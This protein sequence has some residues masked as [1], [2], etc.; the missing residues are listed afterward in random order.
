[1]KASCQK[2]NEL[3]AWDLS[4]LYVGIDDPQIEK[5]LAVYQKSALDFA[6]K[7]KDKIASLD[8]KSFFEMAKNCEERSVLG[9]KLGV[10]AYLTMVTQ[11][12]NKEAMT[13]YQNISE[14]LNDY[15]KPTIFLSLEINKLPQNKIDEWLTDKQASY[16]TPWLKRIRMFKDYELSEAVEEILHEKSVTS[17]EGWERLYEET[18]ARLTFHINDT[19]YNDAEISKLTL[20]KDAEIR[21]QAG[22]EIARVYKENAPLFTLNYNMVVKDKA[23]E[24]MKRGFSSPVASQNLA[25]RVDDAAVTALAQ[26]VRNHYADIAHRFYKLKAKWLGVSKLEYWD[27]NAPLPF[28]SERTYSWDEAVKIVLQAYKEFSPKL[29]RLATDFFN[30]QHSWIDVPPRDGKR[31]GAFAMP[32]PDKFH[33]YLFLN[34]VGKQNDVLTLA[35]EL[36]HG[37]HMR[38]SSKQGDLNDST[39][40]TLAEVASVFAEMLTFQSLLRQAQ[41]DKERLCLIAGKV[42]DMINTA[43][44]QI[45]FHFFETR[46]HD[47]RRNGEV[48]QDRLA[49]IWKEEMIASLGDYVNIDEVTENNWAMVGHFFWKP[50]YVY[51]YSF[52]DCLVNSLYQVSQKGD[53]PNFADKYLDMLA[54]TGVKRYD[55][56]LKPFGLDAN[57]PHFWNIGL[58]LISGY[59]DELE[60]LDKKLFS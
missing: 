37:C 3:P 4:D 31:S 21:A 27:R 47:E 33:P 46:V 41:D 16:Y 56:L 51:A 30:P 11:M 32:L 59:I 5:D 12:K 53:V 25:N 34:F 15:S 57:D 38:L 13:F 17:G 43:V 36:G 7:Y 8:A 23:I 55:E 22:K 58:N 26:T 42:N 60:K 19:E 9:N 18:S 10:F 54:L 52:A 50:F 39:P 29:Y 49:Q 14:K 6:S 45:A 24:D 35:H 44:R 1:M 2:N 40:L 48:S 20:D 28:E